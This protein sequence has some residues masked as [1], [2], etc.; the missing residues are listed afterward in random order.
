MFCIPELVTPTNMKP[1]KVTQ[2]V[3]GSRY[4]LHGTNQKRTVCD[5]E[6]K[7]SKWQLAVSRH[8][9]RIT[10]IVICKWLVSNSVLN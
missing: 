8:S 1:A 7:V 3:Q 5:K 9:L 10:F 2:A 4:L 6:I